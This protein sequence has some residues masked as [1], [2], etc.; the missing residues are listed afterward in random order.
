MPPSNAT[1]SRKWCFTMFWDGKEPGPDY[2]D[3]WECD[4]L[5]VGK[6]TCPSTGRLHY[7]GY[8]RY[9]NPRALA[10]VRKLFTHKVLTVAGAPGYPGHWDA[11]KG[12]EAQNVKYCSKDDDLVIEWGD[13]ESDTAV[14][15]QQG[16]RNDIIAVRQ[17]ISEGAGMKDVILHTNSYQAI[18]IAGEMLKYLEVKKTW[19]TKVYWIYGP[20][21]V[22]KTRSSFE[23]C[24]NPW[25]AHDDNKWFDGYDAHADVIIDDFDHNWCSFKGF[26]KLTD[27]YP[28][29][30]PVKGGFRS[31]LPK[32]I[33]ITCDE[34][35]HVIA[36]RW[37]TFG[38]KD[39]DLMQIGRRIT[40]ILYMPRPGEIYGCPGSEIGI[41][42]SVATLFPE[43][44]PE[45]K[46]WGNT[47]EPAD[48]S[49]DIVDDGG[50]AP[51]PSGPQTVS[52]CEY[53]RCN[54][55]QMVNPPVNH[56]TTCVS[57]SKCYEPHGPDF[58]CD[59]CE[60][61]EPPLDGDAA[62][63]LDEELFTILNEEEAP[64][65]PTSMPPPLVIPRIAERN[66]GSRRI[67]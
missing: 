60:F 8:V 9:P 36:A 6:E 35:P 51:A 33:F 7:Q 42:P 38:L 43:L 19:P 67:I 64:P 53:S 15:K 5:Y 47:T 45:Q 24:A 49:Y 54:K 20:S 58:V 14:D 30:V 3:D 18:K 44:E 65:L 10:G 40:Q 11:C 1:K 63:N 48:P 16:K 26:L 56:H 32:R 31:W 59:D 22:N 34:P 57:E 27:R 12:T 62:R 13:R 17:M 41:E 61:L 39:N 4:Y 23:T 21:G 25:M 37:M 46:V 66:R 2:F 52:L 55:C 29:A 50:A 28:K